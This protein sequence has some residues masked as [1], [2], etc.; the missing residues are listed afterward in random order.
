MF[1]V[2]VTT[3]VTV[4]TDN[5][6][7]LSVKRTV[8]VRLELDFTLYSNRLRAEEYNFR[9]TN[10]ERPMLLSKQ[11]AGCWHTHA[12]AGSSTVSLGNQLTCHTLLPTSTHSITHP[13]TIRSEINKTPS[14]ISEKNRETAERRLVVMVGETLRGRREGGWEGGFS[15]V[16]AVCS[17]W[18]EMWGLQKGSRKNK[19]RSWLGNSPFPSLPI[20]SSSSS[21]GSFHVSTP[22]YVTADG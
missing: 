5:R 12:P 17:L 13:N 19:C 2:T 18:D 6:R 1:R 16:V 14:S 4:T 3:T 15:V 7:S 22:H 11:H 21:S 10:P 9:T 20:T 8:S